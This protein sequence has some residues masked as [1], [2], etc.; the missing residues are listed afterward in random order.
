MPDEVIIPMVELLHNELCVKQHKAAKQEQT[1][2]ELKLWC[3][4]VGRGWVK[5]VQYSSKQPIKALEWVVGGEG[6]GTG[7]EV[8]EERERVHGQWEEEE[9][10]RSR[11]EEEEK[12]KRGGCRWEVEERGG[13]RR[14]EEEEVR[15]GR[16][17]GAGGRWRREEGAGGRRKRRCIPASQGMI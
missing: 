7:K 4:C 14:E 16:G 1:K 15:R 9:R 10:G 6:T 5:L 2:V 12:G 3:V 13:S 8:R 11:R 17:E